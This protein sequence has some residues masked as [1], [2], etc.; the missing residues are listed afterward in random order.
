MCP[1][2]LVSVSYFLAHI[3]GRGYDKFLLNS[4]FRMELLGLV[5]YPLKP[6]DWEEVVRG[7]GV[8]G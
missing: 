1:V 4:N 6:Q 7:L 5:E 3:M 8:Q 2:S